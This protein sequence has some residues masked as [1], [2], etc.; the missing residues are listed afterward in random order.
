MALMMSA[1]PSIRLRVGM[2]DDTGGA[3]VDVYRNGV[4]I[5]T[6]Y[7]PTLGISFAKEYALNV[8]DTFYVMVYGDYYHGYDYYENGVYI[9][10]LFDYGFPQPVTSPT[11]TA[12]L[13]ILYDFDCRNVL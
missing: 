6:F 2:L 13:G 8:G 3:Y 12:A 1:S 9:N 11:Q 5:D 7:P 4:L 10:S